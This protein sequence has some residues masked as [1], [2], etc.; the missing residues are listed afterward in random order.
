MR[1]PNYFII[2][3]PKCGTTSL[4]AW[5][6]EHPNIYMPSTKEPHFFNTDHK[7]YLNS[8]QGYERLFEG[9]TERHFA[10]G[11]ASVWYLYSSTA[12]DN[13]LA[14]NADAKFI[15]MLRNPVDMAPSL[16][17]ELLFTGRESIQAFEV[18]WDLQEI[19]RMGRS[20]P[21]MVWE[22]K[23]VQY[24]DVCSLGAQVRRLYQ[25]VA[26]DRIK[27]ILLDDMKADP[28]ATYLSTLQFLCVDDDQRIDFEVHNQ[29]KERHWPMLLRLPWLAIHAKRALGIEG[30]LGLWRHVDAWTRVERP[31]APIDAAMKARLQDYFRSDIRLLETLVGRPLEHWLA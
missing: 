17:E 7:R 28:R 26:A 11:E 14:Y 15:I 20:L 19:R 27:A 1:K 9:A 24:A 8:L 21:R 16:H 3:A 13:I 2:G 25:R 4:A 30:G 6:S 5:L 18:A 31:R 29:S 12:V 23:Y 10:V 22:P